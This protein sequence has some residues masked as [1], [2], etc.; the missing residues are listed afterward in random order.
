MT[1]AGRLKGWDPGGARGG[2]S[3]RWVAR[4]FVLVWLVYLAYPLSRVFSGGER[5]S[6][7]VQLSGAALFV[8]V[9]LW[10]VLFERPYWR[11]TDPRRVINHRVAVGAL[12]GVALSL[13][14]L[15]GSVWAGLFVYASVAAGIS[16]PPRESRPVIA[17]LAVAVAVCCVASGMSWTGVGQFVL[18][19]GGIGFGQVLWS[20]LFSTVRELE[21][22]REEIARL[23]VAE[24]RLRFARDLH[25][26]LGHSLS[27]IAVKSEVARK[28]ADRDPRRATAE[29]REVEEISRRALG[30]V[31]EAVSGYRRP[32]LEAEIA[33]AT[34]MLEAAGVSCEIERPGQTLPAEVQE[35]FCWVIRESVTNVIRHSGARRCWIRAGAEGRTCFL[36][37]RDDGRG[38][39]GGHPSGCGLSGLS[40]RV[41]AGGGNLFAG[42]LPARGFRVRAE[43]PW[44]DSVPRADRTHRR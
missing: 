15:Y 1:N 27:L 35:I 18:L 32:V 37:V 25:D 42:P 2:A 38:V 12:F 19:V 14:L 31:R 26:L 43:L 36:E 30:E 40:E 17:M 9:Y 28:V 10:V 4:L 22:A 7:V 44:R 23:A 24:E 11:G 3:S 8:V 20:R 34:Q 41:R 21:A 29:M 6:V 33:N 39:T 13:S 16:L 5:I